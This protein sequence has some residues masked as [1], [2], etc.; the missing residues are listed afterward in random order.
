MFKRA[1]L[2]ALI[3]FSFQSYASQK[4]QS[5][6][7][8]RNDV[9]TVGC[10]WKCSR[11]NRWGIKRAARRAGYKVNIVNLFSENST[12]DLSLVDAILM[13]GGADINPK[14]YISKVERGLQ[15]HIKSLDY[16]VDYSKEGDMRDPFEYNLLQTYFS[17]KSHAL[18]P[19]L[20]I[21][22]G[23]QMLS[24]SQGIPLY[25]DIKKELGFR[26][27]RWKLDKIYVTNPESVVQ[28]EIRD[29]KFRAVKYHHQG[30]RL[31]YF[32]EHA[33]RWPNL[34]VTSVSNRG[35]IAESL[36]F[37]DRPVL[38]VQYHPEWTFGKVRRGL[39]GWLLNRAC[40]KKQNDKSKVLLSGLK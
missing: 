38:G 39:F 22:R 31:N 15:E 27:R 16:L 13:P 29:D 21:C 17:S 23:M 30:L 36:E 37:Y 34:E 19:I 25:V 3:L 2:F 4:S 26:N 20:G 18:T 11:W 14:Y 24:V 9:I 10:T 33:E 5:C 7:L 28:S 6:K 32:N 8:D 12:P 35:K 40:L 1:L